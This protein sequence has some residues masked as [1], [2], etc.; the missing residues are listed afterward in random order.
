MNVDI[1]EWSLI[2]GTGRATK[3]YPYETWGG[4]GGGV[5]MMKGLGTVGVVFFKW[6]GGGGEK[7]YPVL[8]EGGGPVPNMGRA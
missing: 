1:R 7:F 6:V 4:G 3:R 8:G 5:V 2:T